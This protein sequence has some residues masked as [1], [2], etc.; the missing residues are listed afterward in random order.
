MYS[1]TATCGCRRAISANKPKCA[2]CA[3][4]TVGV[5]KPHRFGQAPPV[6]P[7][8]IRTARHLTKSQRGNA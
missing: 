2:A 1:G 6:Q 3:G 7:E 8:V 5:E 4:V